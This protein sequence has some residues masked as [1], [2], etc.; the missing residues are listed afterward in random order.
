VDSSVTNH[1]A[2]LADRRVYHDRIGGGTNVLSAFSIIHSFS[3]LHRAFD[4]NSLFISPT[5]AL[6]NRSILMLTH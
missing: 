4:L 1:T 6:I 3:L 5:Y 2:A